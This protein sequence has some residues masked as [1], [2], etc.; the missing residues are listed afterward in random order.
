[1]VMDMRPRHKRI[2]VVEDDQSVA[3]M[4][5][6]ALRSAGFDVEHVSSGGAA[7]L[8]LDTGTHGAVL[9]DL[10]LPDRRGG[11]VVKR[12]SSLTQDGRRGPVWIVLSA[13]DF[14][15]AEKLYSVPRERFVNK[16]FDP[17]DIVKRLD[18]EMSKS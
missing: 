7:L 15:D 14:S 3:R 10:G 13:M 1:M 8:A 16:P 17:W 2:L 12:L 18:I 4:L 5:S 11:D 6:L 9:L